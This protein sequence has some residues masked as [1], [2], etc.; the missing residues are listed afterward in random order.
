MDRLSTLRC[1]W[2]LGVLGCS[3]LI[4][5]SVSGCKLGNW[6]KP[7]LPKLSA[8]NGPFARFARK[9]DDQPEPPPSRYFEED[10]DNNPTRVAV[11]EPDIKRVAAL[12]S[13]PPSRERTPTRPDTLDA[14]N[15][16]S[17]LASA[18]NR[19]AP[20][21]LAP[22]ISSSTEEFRG[23]EPVRS[24]FGYPDDAGSLV[25]GPAGNSR[26]DESRS[27]QLASGNQSP[28]RDPY[29]MPGTAGSAAPGAVA[30][31]GERLKS[32]AGDLDR[33]MKRF[34]TDAGNRHG[35]SQ[36]QAAD[37]LKEAGREADRLA[38]NLS[39]QAGL[40]IGEAAGDKAPPAPFRMPD[41]QPGSLA[42]PDTAP[43]PSF[44]PPANQQA[45]A[46]SSGGRF[47]PP[48]TASSSG[49]NTGSVPG[50]SL[51]PI[52]ER[53]NVVQ[54]PH[55]GF[56][57]LTGSQGSSDNSSVAKVNVFPKTGASS[58]SAGVSGN[59]AGLGGQGGAGALVTTPREPPA[60]QPQPGALA[61]FSSPT[62]PPGTQSG[63]INQNWQNSPAETKPLGLAGNGNPAPGSPSSGNQP[64]ANPAPSNRFSPPVASTGMQPST[65]GSDAASAIATAEPKTG[66]LPASLMKRSGSYLPGSTRTAS[67]PSSTFR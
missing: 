44:V 10:K 27:N 45:G 36:E 9:K 25:G 32:A 62:S 66:G 61:G 55:S 5:T 65:S 11:E 56:Q 19:P 30:N 8:E 52:P 35:Q 34:S 28:L 14:G 6:P 57:P 3:L 37:R 58:F 12:D 59:N 33:E 24:G 7:T 63:S 42:G 40:K 2:S 54:T 29:R 51:S 39:N 38:N 47:Q 20:N 43:K 64:F 67:S 48:A 1:R 50:S 16:N 41:L 31:A 26:A 46:S 15:R 18:G 13:N 21:P 22:K 4:G 53:P 60:S 23:D 17:Q 49:G